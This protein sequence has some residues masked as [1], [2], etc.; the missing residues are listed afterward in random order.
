MNRGATNVSV[1][2]K[3]NISTPP[4]TETETRVSDDGM[5]V[6][7][8]MTQ[9]ENTLAGRI[10]KG[11]PLSSAFETQYGMNRSAGVFR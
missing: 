7:I 2:P 1:T 10:R 4:N 3:I 5:N 8:M 9:I 6:D 11:G